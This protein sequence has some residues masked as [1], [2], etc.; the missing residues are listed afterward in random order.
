MRYI[1]CYDIPVDK[2]RTAVSKILLDYGER[3]QWSVFECLMESAL[4]PEMKERIL[5]VAD[6]KEDAIRVYTICARCEKDIEIIGKG[7][8]IQEPEVYIV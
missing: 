1:V 5:A 2:R 4:L 8:V 6:E 3:V 7:V